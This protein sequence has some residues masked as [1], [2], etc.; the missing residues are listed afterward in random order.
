ME[1]LCHRYGT[2]Q[3]SFLNFVRLPS[4]PFS[5]LLRSLWIAALQHIDCASRFEVIHELAENV[6]HLTVWD[7]N[8]DVIWPSMKP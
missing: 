1:L 2:W 3:F 7:A 8:Q 4:A 5:S 6:F